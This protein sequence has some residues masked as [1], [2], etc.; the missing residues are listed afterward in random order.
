MGSAQHMTQQSLNKC[1]MQITRLQQEGKNQSHRKLHNALSYLKKERYEFKL[2]LKSDK[3]WG[4]YAQQRFLYEILCQEHRSRI[5]SEPMLF[6]SVKHHD[7]RELIHMMC[8]W[9]LLFIFIFF[10][11]SQVPPSFLHPPLSLPSF[12]SSCL[13]PSCISVQE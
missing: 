10:C 11:F 6:P 4:V 7:S 9:G 8:L 12:L 3:K 1:S 5:C 13:L 2:E